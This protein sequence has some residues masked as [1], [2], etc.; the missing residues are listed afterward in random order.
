[1]CRGN[2]LHPLYV[3][4]S[5]IIMSILQTLPVS[6]CSDLL[7]EYEE[8]LK[9]SPED[10]NLLYTLYR[11]SYTAHK[12]ETFTREH[13][14]S[15]ISDRVVWAIQFMKIMELDE[16]GCQLFADRYVDPFFAEYFTEEEKWKMA[17][18]L[19]HGDQVLEAVVSIIVDDKDFAFSVVGE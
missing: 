6:L 11:E 16:G 19:Q 5:K 7:S 15:F 13:F 18:A 12:T 8:L 9:V 4:Y 10:T 3:L 1:M 2:N 17:S 14:I